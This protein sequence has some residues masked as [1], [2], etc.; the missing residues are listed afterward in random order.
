MYFDPEVGNSKGLG[1]IEQAIQ[2]QKLE[3]LNA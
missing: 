1:L 3:D 2:L